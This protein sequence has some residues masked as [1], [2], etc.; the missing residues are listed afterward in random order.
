MSLAVAAVVGLAFLGHKMA[1]YETDDT[2]EVNTTTRREKETAE[3]KFDDYYDVQQRA[4]ANQTFYHKQEKVNFGDISEKANRTV[5]GEPV[6]DVSQREY[7]TNKMNNVNPNP[8]TR[9]GPGIGVGPNVPAYGGK[10]QLFRV[11]PVNVNEH[12][13][14]Q[15]SERP[16]APPASLVALGESRAP[17][18]KNRP[19]K[20]WT[21]EP[22]RGTFK[23][24]APPG[25]PAEVKGSFMTKKDQSIYRSDDLST[26]IPGYNVGMGH[27]VTGKTGLG[28]STN[29]ENPDRAGNAD[30]MNVTGGPLAQNG[31]I[32]SVRID[33]I[34][35]PTQHG[36]TKLSY[37][38]TEQ[39]EINPYKEKPGPSE[40]YPLD[41]AKKQLQN[42]PYNHS[43][44]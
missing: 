23:N 41:T 18:A 40:V 38:R 30:R 35:L 20:V 17:V 16:G 39:Q 14:T 21:R 9:V 43:I 31:M 11:L 10:Q 13:L 44:N 36:A 5:G 8:W 29:R 25:R 2:V 32:T 24:E 15:L 27:I 12:R 7:I 4:I 34:E 37:A 33:A 6:Y 42:N 26:G 19:E 28:L 22:T 3:F 1:T